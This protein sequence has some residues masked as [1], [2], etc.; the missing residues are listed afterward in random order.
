MALAVIA[1]RIADSCRTEAIILL[2]TS[3]S[4]V[5]ALCV[6]AAD[7]IWLRNVGKF[8]TV[9]ACAAASCARLAGVGAAR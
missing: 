7:V 5:V 3:V 4:P 8:C 1:G 6:V 2:M 9:A